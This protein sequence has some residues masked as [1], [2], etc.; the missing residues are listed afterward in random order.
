MPTM[1][2]LHKQSAD[3]KLILIGDATMSPDEIEYA[4]G[5]VFL[6]TSGHYVLPR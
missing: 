3:Y 4:G 2:L 1:D 5:S 6:L